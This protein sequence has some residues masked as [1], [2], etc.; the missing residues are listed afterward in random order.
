AVAQ[1]LVVLAEAFLLTHDEDRR[2]I[3]RDVPAVVGQYGLT[4]GGLLH[5][6]AFEQDHRAI[7]KI[8]GLTRL[9]RCRDAVTPHRADLPVLVIVKSVKRNER[10]F[11]PCRKSH[12]IDLRG[13]Q[14]LRVPYEEYLR[15]EKDSARNN[16][17]KTAPFHKTPLFRRFVPNCPGI[18]NGWRLVCF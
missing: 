2:E 12:A 9:D 17:Y 15:S 3:R 1:L 18:C 5:P 7:R 13:R 6:I 14:S 10:L 4:A 8:E 16:R 11:V